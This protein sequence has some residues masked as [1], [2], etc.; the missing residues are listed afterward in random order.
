MQ[1]VAQKLSHLD[2]DNSRALEGLLAHPALF[3]SLPGGDARK[4]LCRHLGH[5]MALDFVSCS[6]QNE[7]TENL[8]FF[9]T[10]PVNHGA[11]LCACGG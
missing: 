9:S 1:E 6:R 11:V 7:D 8:P 3:S 5:W 4:L 10:P 2:P